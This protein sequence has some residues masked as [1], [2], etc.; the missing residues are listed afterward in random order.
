M[1]QRYQNLKSFLCSVGLNTM[2]FISKSVVWLYICV[3]ELTIRK[4]WSIA[5][6]GIGFVA[7]F[8]YVTSHI[9]L[10]AGS[11]H[12][13]MTCTLWFSCIKFTVFQLS[14][15]ILVCPLNRGSA[16]IICC[17]NVYFSSSRLTPN[18]W[19]YV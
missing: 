1:I 2:D 10:W 6:W 11:K 19:T 9:F 16:F 12:C 13:L 14:L 18:F 15:I 17:K 8:F 4:R 3:Y 7:S 5:Y